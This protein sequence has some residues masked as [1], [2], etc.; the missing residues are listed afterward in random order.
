LDPTHKNIENK[1]AS[2]SQ[3]TA[4]VL[5]YLYDIAKQFG[6]SYSTRFVR[7]LT[8]SKLRD[9]E[10][11]IIDLSSSIT[12]HSLFEKWCFSR[13]WIATTDNTGC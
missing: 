9:E 8:K 2:A 12:E 7:M 5:F 10:R 3:E 1:N 13:G 6:E 4:G 11:G